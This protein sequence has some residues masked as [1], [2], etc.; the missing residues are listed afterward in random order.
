MNVTLQSVR[1]VS[2]EFASFHT[3][4]LTR[5]MIASAI[6]MTLVTFNHIVLR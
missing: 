6:V 1:H 2:P 5:I 4:L 3:W